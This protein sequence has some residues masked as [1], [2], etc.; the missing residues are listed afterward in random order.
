MS[1][2]KLYSARGCPFAHRTRLVLTEKK[3]PFELIEIDLQNKPAWFDAKLSG[4]GKVPA[5]E[6]DGNHIW[7]STIVNEYIEEVFPEPRLLPAEPGLR[8]RARIFIDYANTRF[9]T[10]FGK[11]LRPAAGA[12][13]AAGAR[14]LIDSLNYIE[15]AGLE[16]LSGAGPFFLG[17]QPSLVDFAFYPWFERWAALQHYRGLAIPQDLSRLQRWR[18][19]VRELPSVRKHENLTEYYIQ[20]YAA[21]VRPS[22]RA[23]A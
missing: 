22:P 14:A 12:D 23:V 5:L 2:I 11:V 20:R 7:E 8:A 21:N 17:S 13:E 6:H 15:H 10:A 16:Q 1:Q 18:E 3:V 19:A 4:Y 9:V